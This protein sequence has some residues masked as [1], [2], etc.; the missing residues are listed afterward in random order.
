MPRLRKDAQWLDG[1]QREHFKT[2][3]VDAYDPN[4]FD[5]MLFRQLN[6]KRNHI[7]LET[8]LGYA[9]LVNKVIQR[10]DEESWSAQLLAAARTERQDDLCLFRFAQQFDLEPTTQSILQLVEEQR[11][12]SDIPLLP[13]SD[14]L[15]TGLQRIGQVCRVAI[16]GASSPGSGFLLGPDLVLTN[17]HVVQ[18]IIEHNWPSTFIEI[19]FDYHGWSKSV[20][21]GRQV[22]L[23]PH[24][25]LVDWSKNSSASTAYDSVPPTELDY[26]LIRT[27]Q[28]VG[29]DRIDPQR[30]RGWIPISPIAAEF[31]PESPLIILGHP[32][33]QATRLS[34]DTRSVL[35]TNMSFT[36]VRYRTNTDGGSSGSPCFNLNWDLVALHHGGDVSIPPAFNEGIPLK[37]LL[38]VWQEKSAPSSTRHAIDGTSLQPWQQQLLRQVLAQ[39]FDDG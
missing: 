35:S 26:A 25:W 29:D 22:K 32:L 3:L 39:S 11:A 7:I 5:E 9:T 34:L 23:P 8:N 24:E 31:K 37:A 30:T 36:R 12:V 27:T 16:R 21:Q 13:A 38:N 18:E 15:M 17:Y 20:A 28:R 2:C 6:K 10:A 19:L 33:N 4:A 14:W 1:T